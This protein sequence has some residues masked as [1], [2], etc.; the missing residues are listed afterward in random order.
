MT[1]RAD[2]VAASERRDRPRLLSYVG[3]WGRARRWLPDEAL[4]VADVGCAFGYGTAALRG[5]ART[6]T[7]IGIERDPAHLREASRRFPWLRVLVGD[8]T[9]IPLEDA[10]VDAVVMLD[11]LEHLDDPRA[12]LE[13]A[14][15]VLRAGGAI[16]LSVPHRGPLGFLDALNIYPALRRR[17]P[18]WA[19]LEPADATGPEGHRHFSVDDVRDLLRGDFEIDR[20]A[21]TGLGL[22]EVV[23][24]GLLVAFKGLFRR[25]AVY[26]AL[27]PL[28][29][30]LYLLDD[31]VPTGRWG[32]YLTVRASSR[33]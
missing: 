32:Y 31:L 10:S 24:L 26:R 7:V 15:R 16:V 11:V 21:R 2:A 18:T 9:A 6:R 1:A 28:H 23:H 3:R 27:L 5:G 17:F 12:A 30:A 29:F 19:P 25:R 4:V 22:A 8:A 20:V 33:R 14:R 13:E